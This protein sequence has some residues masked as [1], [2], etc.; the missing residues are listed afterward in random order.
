MTD[1]IKHECGIA[2]IRLLK[3]LDYYYN[4]YGSWQYGLDKLYLL[5]EKQHNR[6]QEGAGL[7]AV[8]LEASPGN[9]YIFRE[10][11]MGSGAISEIFSKVHESFQKFTPEQLRDIEFVKKT[12][13]YAAELFIGHLRYSTTGKSGLTYVHPLLRRNNWASRSLALAGNFNMTNVDEMF[14]QLIAEGQHPRDYADTFVM[15]ESIGHYLDREVQYQYDHL[16]KNHVSGQEASHVI[17]EKLDIP[18]LL[19]RASKIWDGGYALCGLVGCGDAFALRDPWGIRSAFYYYDDEVAVVASERPVIQTAFNLKKE[20]VH[21]LQPGE[22][23]VVKKNGHIGLH[24]IQERKEKIT[25]CSFERI[26]FS[27]GSDYDIYRERKK[28]GELLVPKIIEAIDDDFDNTV[29][30]FIP[31]TAEVAYYGMLQGLEDYFN[32]KK[33]STIL[34][35]G[36]SL[37]KEEIDQILSRRVR[38]E[39]VAIKDIK[40][41]TFIAQGNKRNDLAAHVYDV[42]YGSLRRGKDNLVIIDDSIVRGTT[43]KQSIIKILDR[44]DPKKIVIVSSSPQIRYPDC[45]GIDMSRMSEFI[46]F[47]AAIALLKERGMQHI[48]DETYEKSVAQ[49][50]KS[51]EEIVNYVKDIYAPFTDEEI[52][53]KIAQMLTSSDIKAEVKIVFQSIEDLHKAC[54]GNQGDWYFSGNYPT[55]GGNRLVNNAFINY[56]EGQEGLPHQYSLNF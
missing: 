40:L 37:S 3:P 48:I 49:S 12:V 11:A 39:K 53:T 25:P 50:R 33:T 13:P 16:E 51:K 54:P 27:R 18:F 17:E 38:S 32:H 24:Q 35:K 47:R 23:I 21:E 56:V 15:L 4:K 46:A 6:G 2:V 45:Y 30:S 8:K 20:E 42:T 26:Y 55:P 10:R 34:E 28:L 52:S 14:Q 5:M 41:R 43:L 22:A 1:I 7:G 29:F 36:N 19:K 9:E 44:L 31:N